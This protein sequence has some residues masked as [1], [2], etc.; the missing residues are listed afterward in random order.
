GVDAYDKTIKRMQDQADLGQKIQ[1]IQMSL[2]NIWESTQGAIEATLAKIGEAIGPELKAIAN[3]MG[4]MADKAGDLI[5]KY[6]GLTKWAAGITAIGGAALLA[7]GTL[8]F[9]LGAAIS[10]FPAITTGATAVG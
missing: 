8:L 2:V 6:P 10:I 4:D 1:E 7:G 9:G 3:W 5:S